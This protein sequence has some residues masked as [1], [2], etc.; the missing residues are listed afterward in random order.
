[1]PGA[2]APMANTYWLVLGVVALSVFALWIIVNS[3]FGW[4]LRAHRENRPRCESIGMNMRRYQLINFVLSGFFVG[5]AGGL[6]AILQRGAYAEF[7]FWLKSG[8]L[9]IMCLLGGMFTFAGPLVGGALLVYLD[10]LAPAV[11][12]YWALFKGIILLVCVLFLPG[13][14]LGFIVD[15]IR[16]MRERWLRIEEVP[17]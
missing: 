15:K 10:Y 8:D 4:T 2:L 13:G 17:G 5:I 1:M 3:P 6:F 14:I 9:L 12:E 16:G 11:T 7:A